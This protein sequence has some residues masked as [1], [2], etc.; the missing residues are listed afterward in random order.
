MATYTIEYFALLRDQ[1]GCSIETVDSDAV[2]ALALYDKLQQDH[3]LEMPT[4]SLKVAVNGEFSTWDC[5]LS[6]GDTIVFIPPVA[7]G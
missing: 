5:A 7:G 1:R 6:D 3:G 2:T 4:R